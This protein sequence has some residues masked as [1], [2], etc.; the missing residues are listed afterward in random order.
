[1]NVPRLRRGYLDWL[2]GVAVLIM[3]EAHLVD[4]WTR[5]PDRETG[6]F[7][8]AMIVGGFG[9]PLF[10][11]L[12]GVAVPLSAGSK[13]RRSGDRHAA[14]SAVVR[15]GV[16]IFGLAFLFR[17][18]AWILGWASPRTLLRVDILNI[19]GPSIAAAAA[20]WGVVSTRRARYVTF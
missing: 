19:M 10:L 17:L 2:R 16:E 20:L 18:Q 11:F 9:A 12:A 14:S 4:S 1:M 8:W 7:A 6:Q 3:I 15:R 5:F 13:Q